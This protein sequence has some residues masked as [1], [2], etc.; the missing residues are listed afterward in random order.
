MRFL[1]QSKAFTRFPVVCAISYAG[2]TSAWVA[3][4]ND[5]LRKRE[6]KA[7][8]TLLAM[9][10]I[11]LKRPAV[12][13]TVA[14]EVLHMQ[15]RILVLASV[16]L[17]CA[18]AAFGQA[19][20]GFGPNGVTV[21]AGVPDAFQ[22]HVIANVT[23]PP[24]S[25]LTYAATPGSGFVNMT[26]A[27]SLGADPFGPGLLNHV[28]WICVNVYAFSPDEQEIACC[29]CPITP[30][31]AVHITASDIVTNTLTAV[32]PQNITV[33]LL[34]T[35]P[36]TSAA[37]PGVATQAAFTGTACNPAFTGYTAANLAPG[38]RAWAVTAHQ[39]PTAPP[40]LGITESSFL[41]AALSPGELISLT[42]RCAGII[43]NG[44]GAG[45]CRGCTL[46]VLGAGLKK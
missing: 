45:T 34:A 27:G 23:P 31:G 35:I 36:G 1:P 29:S 43:G 46:G 20:A 32:I 14:E 30:N 7:G 39:L 8:L 40:A 18:T 17:L 2:S 37:A 3:K 15:M 5:P 19:I 26:N 9:P 6:Q 25:G 38:L 42:N 24:G 41:P 22:V 4:R 21:S 10:F 44:T 11:E 12:A 28:G 33:K 13:V 16:V